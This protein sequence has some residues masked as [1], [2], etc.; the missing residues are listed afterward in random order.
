MVL[1]KWDNEIVNGVK[2]KLGFLRRLSG[3]HTSQWTEI[4]FPQTLLGVERNPSAK[5]KKN[6]FTGYGDDV[7]TEKKTNKK[8]KM[9]EG[10]HIC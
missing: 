10:G 2:G 7:I 6:S 5:F 9:A 8:N 3:H 1:E 4:I